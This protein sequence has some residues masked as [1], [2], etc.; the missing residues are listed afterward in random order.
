ML[1]KIRMMARDKGKRTLIDLIFG[2][3]LLDLLEIILGALIAPTERKLA[4]VLGVLAGLVCASFMMIHMYKT[5]EQA[6]LLDNKNAKHKTKIGAFLRMLVMV[7]TLILTA[8]FNDYVSL[9][10]T[11]LGILSLKISAL[12]QPLIDKLVIY[13]TREEE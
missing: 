3:A 11:F 2:T 4:Y 8:L 12:S 6:M 13:L 9:I 7:G 1:E 5:L 10:G